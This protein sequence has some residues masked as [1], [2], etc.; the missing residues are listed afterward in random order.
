MGVARHPEAGVNQPDQGLIVVDEIRIETVFL[1]LFMIKRTQGGR[2]VR[3]D[4]VDLAGQPGDAV[5]DLLVFRHVAV[6]VPAQRHPE[7]LYHRAVIEMVR[8]APEIRAPLGAVEAQAPDLHRVVVEI[9]KPGV[10][11]GVVAPEGVHFPLRGMV[12]LVIARHEDDR[13]ES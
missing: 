11:F 1:V 9:I 2:E 7:I 12:V 6:G 5:T 13:G 8:V 4:H 3:D 10:P